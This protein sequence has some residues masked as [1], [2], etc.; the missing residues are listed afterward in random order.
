MQKTTD[1]EDPITKWQYVDI[2]IT[3]FKTMTKHRK[4]KQLNIIEAQIKQN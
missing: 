3:Y 4:K 1:L 2:L